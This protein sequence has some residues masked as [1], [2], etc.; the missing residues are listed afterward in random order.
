MKAAVAAITRARRAVTNRFAAA[1]K[2]ELVDKHYSKWGPQMA[3][4]WT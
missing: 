4:C 3:G 2:A 1:G